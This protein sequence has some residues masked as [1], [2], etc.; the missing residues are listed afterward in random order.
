LLAQAPGFV[1]GVAVAEAA[2]M[3]FGAGQLTDRLDRP[4]HLVTVT[5]MDTSQLTA[6]KNVAFLDLSREKEQTQRD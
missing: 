3:Y 4:E 6:Q 1:L 2:P 5:R